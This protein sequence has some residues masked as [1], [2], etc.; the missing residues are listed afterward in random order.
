MSPLE[1]QQKKKS[2]YQEGSGF[3]ENVAVFEVCCATDEAKKN[4]NMHVCGLKH[5]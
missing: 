3:D 4:Q 2:L 5:K 1:K